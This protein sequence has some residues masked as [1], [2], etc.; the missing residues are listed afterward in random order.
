MVRLVVAHSRAASNN[1]DKAQ[2]FVNGI[3]DTLEQFRPEVIP[4]VI[5]TT[6]DAAFLGAGHFK[7]TGEVVQFL[8]GAPLRA[9]RRILVAC[10]SSQHLDVS[11][12]LDHRSLMIC[13]LVL[14]PATMLFSR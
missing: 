8:D 5:P 1:T 9:R 2:I 13:R 14:W 6:A 4:A 7:A 10:Y 11:R 12:A 3:R